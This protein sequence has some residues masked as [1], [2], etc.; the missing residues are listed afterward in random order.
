VHLTGAREDA[1]RSPI[2]LYGRLAA[3]QSDVS[4][5]GADFAPTSQQQAVFELFTQ[6]LGDAST[7][8]AAFM[9]QELRAF[10]AELRK[11]PLKDIVA[12][13]VEAGTLPRTGP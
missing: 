4:E 7:R 12:G 2:Q 1:F 9:D 13:G 10:G 11:T 3:L 8:F 5:S 6:R